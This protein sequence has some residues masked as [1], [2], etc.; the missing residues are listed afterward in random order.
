M[1]TTRDDSTG[2]QAL[3]QAENP[4]RTSDI[5]R[6]RNDQPW[7]LDFEVH[8]TRFGVTVATQQTRYTL[9]IKEI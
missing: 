6:T 1:T 2:K 7:L 8:A 4:V 9:P 3:A 5:E